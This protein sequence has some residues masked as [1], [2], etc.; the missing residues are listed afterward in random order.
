[1]VQTYIQNFF[2]EIF[3]IIILCFIITKAVIMMYV[4]IRKDYINVFIGSVLPTSSQNIRNTFDRRMKK[5]LTTSNKV[6]IF[7]YVLVLGFLFL[8]FLL[9]A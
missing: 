7:F 8:Y 2:A 1:M 5:Y 9:G 4:K 6:N 3:I